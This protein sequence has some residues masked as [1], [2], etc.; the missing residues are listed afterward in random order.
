MKKKN[1][2]K[3]KSKILVIVAIAVVVVGIISTVLLL[4]QENNKG[5]MSGAGAQ[6]FAQ[7]YTTVS[8]DNVFTYRN[9]DEIIRIMQHGTG[10]VYLGFP[11]CPWCQA[12]VK[13]LNEVAKEVGITNIYY[14]NISDDRAN[15]TD[16]YQKVIALLDGNLQNDNEGNPRIYVPN[17]SFHIEGKLIG[18]DYET[19][20]DTLGHSSPDDYWTVERTDNLKKILKDNM[21][22]I[23]DAGGE[24]ETTCD[25]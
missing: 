23:I 8:D 19:S 12:Y 11:E 13:H 7:E 17:V 15:N 20:K 9:I 22:Q 21:Q 16:K 2:N 4:S 3:N 6:Q 5:D 10:V 18:N 14:F 1:N 24:C 25:V